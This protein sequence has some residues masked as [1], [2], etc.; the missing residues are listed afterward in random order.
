LGI[1]KEDNL[2]EKIVEQYD[3]EVE[4]YSSFTRKMKDLVVEILKENGLNIH[5][6]THRVK[7]RDSLIKKLSKPESNYADLHDVTDTSGIRI[8]T[9]FE[10]DVDKVAQLIEQEF[11]VDS[12]NSVDK[13][14]LS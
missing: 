4:L 6:V 12:A 11:E 9:Y 3:R 5:S 2:N 10:D 13:R 7:D 8:I 14:A 1:H